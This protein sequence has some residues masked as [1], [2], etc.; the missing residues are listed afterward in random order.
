MKVDGSTVTLASTD[1]VSISDADLTIT[2]GTAVVAAQKVTVS[3]TAPSTNPLQDGDG[4][5]AA[6]FALPV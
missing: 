2:L 3:Y 4:N 6:A 5:D 1:P